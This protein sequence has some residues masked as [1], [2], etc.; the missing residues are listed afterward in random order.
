MSR[1]CELYN[2]SSKYEL[3]CISKGFKFIAGIDEAGRGPIAGPLV[4]ASCILPEDFGVEGITDSKK[5]SEKKRQYLFDLI[6]ENSIS[7]SIE[8]I[9]PASIENKNILNAVRNSVFNLYENMGIKPDVFL[10]DSFKVPDGFTAC[11]SVSFNKADLL[12]VSV[13]AASILAKVARDM[14]MKEIAKEF[15]EYGFDK[16]KGYGTKA[17]YE[18][19]DK[20]G[21]CE[22][23]RQLFLRSWIL[24]KNSLQEEKMRNRFLSFR[25]NT[26]SYYNSVS[27]DK[28]LPGL[29]LYK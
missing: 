9:S 16:H 4:T 25:E 6:R 2:N 23:H 5:L 1:L 14:Y 13:A 21:V 15:P 24:N 26:S 8:F 20:Y 28:V 17:H 19:L 12:S 22:I 10:I 3:E 18:A 29:I 7:F 27:V 11:E